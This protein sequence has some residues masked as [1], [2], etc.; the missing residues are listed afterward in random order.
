MGK[1]INSDSYE[2][3][4]QTAYSKI[5]SELKIRGT[6]KILTKEDR[7]YNATLALYILNN[8]LCQT[9]RL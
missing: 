8:L 5:V 2:N 1:V 4:L 9:A 3:V 7:L 6:D